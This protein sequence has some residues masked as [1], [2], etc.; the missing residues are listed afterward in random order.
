M[1][2]YIDYL[3]TTARSHKTIFNE[4]VKNVGEQQRRIFAKQ[5]STARML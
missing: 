3:H 1:K 4:S 2:H 5:L